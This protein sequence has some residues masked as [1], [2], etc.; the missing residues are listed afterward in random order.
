MSAAS[1]R[2]ARHRLHAVIPLLA[3]AGLL[4]GCG[5][6]ASLSGGS[7]A[8]SAAAVAPAERG[9]LSSAGKAAA[10]SQAAGG[11]AASASDSSATGSPEA[12]SSAAGQLATARLIRTTDVSYEVKDPTDAARRIRAIPPRFGGYLASET[13]GLDQ[14]AAGRG[15]STLVLRVIE[16]K[17]DAALDEVT[18]QAQGRQLSR[19]SSSTDVTG[20]L[21][22]LGSRV[23]TQKAS[24][25]RVR[26]LLGRAGSL[27]DVVLLESELSKRESDLEAVESRLAAISD[28]AEL[29]TLTVTLR[30]AA[31]GPAVQAPGSNGFLTGLRSGWSA[32]TASTTIV[33]TLLGALLPVALV[34]GLLGWPLMLLLLRRRRTGGS[35]PT[36]SVGHGPTAPP[37][38]PSA[39]APEP[40]GAAAE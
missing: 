11:A 26:A 29:A 12:G 40:V 37:A 13:T 16:A 28:Q 8:G 10:G 4:A 35:G 15:V 25:A 33:L 31:T 17:L 2:P 23:S 22:D 39:P 30:S 27:Q 9:A 36:G 24:V 18:R 5:S 19:S 6:G 32:V 7:S 21:A 3:A 1:T 34:A 38:E 20:D 14:V